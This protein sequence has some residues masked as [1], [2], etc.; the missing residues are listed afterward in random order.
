MNPNVNSG[1]SWSWRVTTTQDVDR[2]L[3]MWKALSTHGG[4]WENQPGHS[5]GLMGTLCTLPNFALNLGKLQKTVR[6]RKAWCAAVHGVANSRTR[7]SDW[8]TTT[9]LYTDNKASLN[10]DVQAS[11]LVVSNVL[12]SLSPYLGDLR[13]ELQRTWSLQPTHFHSF[14]WHLLF[15]SLHSFFSK[16]VF[17][18]LL[19][20]IDV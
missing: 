20:L 15:T 10:K 1:L 6:D 17:F 16:I 11:S 13:A 2:R 8:T 19:F 4:W 14:I 18:L 12:T 5:R 7:L 9:L 3:W